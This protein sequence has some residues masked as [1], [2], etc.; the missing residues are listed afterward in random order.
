MIEFEELKRIYEAVSKAIGN[1][2]EPTE[3]L[4]RLRGY[5]GDL[6]ADDGALLASRPDDDEEQSTGLPEE[7][8]R[9]VLED[10]GPGLIRKMC[11]EKSSD[12]QVG[13]FHLDQFNKINQ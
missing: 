2:Q 6:C 7:Q 1:G 5:L 13:I 8:I 10:L 4:M 11:R 9:Y 3:G 12:H